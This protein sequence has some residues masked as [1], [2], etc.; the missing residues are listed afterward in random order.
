MFKTLNKEL[1]EIGAQEAY[2][3]SRNKDIKED[4]TGSDNF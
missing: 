3:P 2:I 4:R 1:K